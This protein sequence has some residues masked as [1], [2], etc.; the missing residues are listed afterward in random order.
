MISEAYSY[1]AD[2]DM[3]NKTNNL[4]V[5]SMV[6]GI[7]S[8]LFQRD[9]LDFGYYEISNAASTKFS[10]LDFFGGEPLVRKCFNKNLKSYLSFDILDFTYCIEAKV[11][12]NH[13]RGGLYITNARLEVLDR[14]EGRSFYID[15]VYNL[16]LKVSAFHSNESDIAKNPIESINFSVELFLDGPAGYD[17]RSTDKFKIRA[18]SEELLF[19][20]FIN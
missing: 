3:T 4:A 18:D 7:S 2:V 11:K 1:E 15:P 5:R 10:K 8:G 13:E 19:C 9:N 6:G 12:L 17:A 16:E 14:F 20:S